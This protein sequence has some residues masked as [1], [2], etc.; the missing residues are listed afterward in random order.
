[1]GEK[2]AQGGRIGVGETLHQT[3][4]HCF[5]VGLGAGHLGGEAVDNAVFVV[6][7]EVFNIYQRLLRTAFAFDAVALDPVA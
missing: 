2:N 5:E 6:A 7:E 4:P 3:L 1:M